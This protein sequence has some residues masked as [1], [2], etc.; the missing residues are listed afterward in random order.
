MRSSAIVIVILKYLK[1]SSCLTDRSS[2]LCCPRGAPS[3][4]MFVR[5][6]ISCRWRV[7]QRIITRPCSCVQIPPFSIN[8]WG[9]LLPWAKDIYILHSWLA[10][11]ENMIA[12]Q[13]CNSSTFS[14]FWIGDS[15]AK[16]WVGHFT[17]KQ[18][19][20]SFSFSQLQM[21]WLRPCD[22]FYGKDDHDSTFDRWPPD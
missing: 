2:P 5:K 12:L 8:T 14:L 13:I 4:H 18:I 20:H 10:L 16:S 7:I 19:H 3:F 1:T 21:W 9:D 11:S 22:L 17:E 6:L 15:G